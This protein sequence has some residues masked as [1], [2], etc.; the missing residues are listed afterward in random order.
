M[1]Y[2]VYPNGRVGQLETTEPWSLSKWLG[3]I[4]MGLAALALILGTAGLATPAV[5]AGLGIAS[6]AFG[7]GSTLAE[8]SEKSEL[9][10]LTQADRDKA[11]LFIAADLASALTLGLGRA[12]SGATR[13]ASAA[14]QVSRFTFVVQRAAAGM[15]V[16]D[17]ALS[18]S[19]MITVT[20]DLIEQY[21]SIQESALP[22]ADKEAALRRLA[23]TGLL[24]G[25]MVVVPHVAGGS[26]HG[27]E[28]HGGGTAA[29]SE[30]TGVHPSGKGPG[31]VITV[32]RGAGEPAAGWGRPHGE[33]DFL[34]WS[35]GQDRLKADQAAHELQLAR[36]GAEA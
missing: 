32:T 30:P 9:G 15:A 27:P 6:A 25:A 24:T 26:G 8:L 5:L 16:V 2:W 34:Q 10:I 11:M 33:T 20:G 12:A 28:V 21:R 14:G 1:L 35:K 4:G 7:I 13:M 18:A 17:T 22:A 19:V 36:R 3:T 31:D 23:L 29:R